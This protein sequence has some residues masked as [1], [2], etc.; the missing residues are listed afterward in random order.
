MSRG[1]WLVGAVSFL[2][3]GIGAVAQR[4]PLV[5][6]PLLLVGGV[7]LFFATRPAGALKERIVLDDTG[8]SDPALGI[9]PIPWNEIIRG[10]LR[11]LMKIWVISL[12][13]TDPD[14]WAKQLPE[15]QRAL[16]GFAKE[17]GLSPILLAVSGLD[18]PPEE[19]LRLINDRARAVPR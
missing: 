9:G 14:R 10:E 13:L 7:I 15:N 11:P 16:R 17:L 4:V 5:G 3:V 12:E 6:W 19:L 1:P 2:V 8:V 18:H